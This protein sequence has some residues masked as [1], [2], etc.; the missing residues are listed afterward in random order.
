MTRYVT[1]PRPVSAT[2]IFAPTLESNTAFRNSPAWV[3]RAGSIGPFGWRTVEA[4]EDICDRDARKN[5]VLKVSYARC[6][7]RLCALYARVAARDGTS[8]KGGGLARSD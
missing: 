1:S 6:K 7:V 4:A 5:G 3:W 8:G 2:R